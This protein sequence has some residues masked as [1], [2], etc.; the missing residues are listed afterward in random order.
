[1]PVY[2]MGPGSSASRDVQR[3][4]ARQFLH[5][6]DNVRQGRGCQPQARH[7]GTVRVQAY[8]VQHSVNVSMW[9]GSC[10]HV[11]H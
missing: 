1:M 8:V 5:Q 9:P 3:A 11:L 4:A 7:S 10:I 2:D 6:M